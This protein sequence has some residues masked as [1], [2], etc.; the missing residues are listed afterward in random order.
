MLRR[1]DYGFLAK[2]RHAQACADMRG[3]IREAL[4]GLGGFSSR[5]DAVMAVVK[6]QLLYEAANA[7]CGIDGKAADTSRLAELATGRDAPAAGTERDILGCR[8]VLQDIFAKPEAMELHSS[9][10]L[11]LHARIAREADP[12]G[13]G[14]CKAKP[15]MLTDVWPGVRIFASH[16]LCMPREA[17]AGLQIWL[18][19]YI[20]ASANPAI[21]R[22][23]LIPCAMLDFIDMSPFAKGSVRMSLLLGAL[24]FC[25]SGI[26]PEVVCV[27]LQILRDMKVDMGIAVAEFCRAE[28]EK[29]LNVWP[30]VRTVLSA[31]QSSLGGLA[32]LSKRWAAGLDQPCRI[33]RFPLRARRPPTT[34]SRTT[35]RER[36]AALSP[37]TCWMPALGWKGQ[38]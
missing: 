8:D 18:I 21:D 5:N 27:L 24:L 37:L 14:E 36:R 32:A 15:C 30:F 7:C 29:I 12:Q 2:D 11:R 13:A 20:K 25:L 38:P 23:L 19:A 26:R 10:I 9:T 1:Y 28:R 35:R 6:N 17:L 33:S 22:L 16:K 31:L 4:A 34:G 3:R